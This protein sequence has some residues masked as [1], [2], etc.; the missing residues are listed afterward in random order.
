MLHLITDG[1][2]VG[3]T[4][5]LNRNE[6]VIGR[7]EGDLKF[8]HDGFMSGRHAR[9]VE[10]GGR[11]FLIDDGSRNGTFIRIGKEI[12]LED[13]DMVLIGKQV[14]RFDSGGS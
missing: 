8:P 9:V 12:A 2:E 13:G 11:Y 6:T 10:R 4:F 7:T 3:E 5:E 14:L 1:G